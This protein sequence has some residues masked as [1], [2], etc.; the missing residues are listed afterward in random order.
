MQHIRANLPELRQRV[1]AILDASQKELLELGDPQIGQSKGALLLHI[2]TTFSNIYSQT[3]DGSL[4]NFTTDELYG[5]ARIS[6]IFNDVFGNY[7][8]SL[9]AVGNLSTHEVQMS[10]SNATVRLIVSIMANLSDISY[11]Y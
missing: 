10:M 4:P 2:I 5:G 8:E 1:S 11:T 9:D 6:F 7:V 3:I